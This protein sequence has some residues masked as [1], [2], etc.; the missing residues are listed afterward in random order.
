MIFIFVPNTWILNIMG[1]GKS[2]KIKCTPF[3][4]PSIDLSDHSSPCQN[5]KPSPTV[6]YNQLYKWNLP[7][8]HWRGHQTSP[9]VVSLKGRLPQKLQSKSTLFCESVQ[10]HSL[11][12]LGFIK[13]PKLQFNRNR[14]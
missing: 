13:K 4:E 6:P 8:F 14:K 2:P 12:R 10:I 7:V 1:N 11:F 5:L 3:S 9:T